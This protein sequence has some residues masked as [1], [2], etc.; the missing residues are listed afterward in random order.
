M[1]NQRQIKI[2]PILI[3]CDTVE[4]AA[5]Q[6][7]ISRGTI[8]GWMKQEEFQN[9]VES[10]RKKLLDRAMN[11][12]LNVAMDAVLALEKLLTAE[13]EAVRRAAAN[14]ILNHIQRQRELK[15]FEGR[16][17]AVEQTLSELRI[18]HH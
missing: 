14:D 16:L 11:K 18:T 5:R 15:E 7:G 12:L 8:Y 2:I 1:L 3:G 6:A 9:A 10:A 13:S 4:E 17:A